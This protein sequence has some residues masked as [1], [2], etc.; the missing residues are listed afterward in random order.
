MADT[1]LNY[2]ASPTGVKFHTSDAFVKGIMGPFGSG[3]SVTVCWDIFMRMKKQAAGSD[4]IRRTRWIIA[5]NTFSELENTTMATWKDWFPER[6]FGFISRKPP[7]RQ[8]IKYDDV[9][10]EIIFLALDK[11]EDQKKLLSFEVTGIWFNEARQIPQELILAA[12]GRVGRYPAR[13]DK[14]GNVDENQWPSWSGILLDTNPPDDTHWY[15]KAAEED[16]WAVNNDGEKVPPESI[17]IKRQ[18]HFFRQ[19]SGLSPQAENIENLPG[20]IEYYQRMLGGN[21]KEWVD[22]HV[23]GNYGF[24]KE[25]MPV[26]EGYWNPDTMVKQINKIPG[27]NIWV[28]IDSSGRHPATVFLQ[29]SSLGQWQVVR[30]YLADANGVG[31]ERYADQLRTFMLSE[32]PNH[33]FYEWGDP[34]GEW[35]TQNDERVYF[36]ILKAKGINVKAS[37]GLRI[38]ERLETVK[39]V[40]GRSINGEPGL[41]I[42]PSCKVLI[43]GLNGGYRYR[44]ISTATSE[45]YDEKP[46]KNRFSDVQDAL[47]Y[48]LCGAGELRKVLGR[49]KNIRGT[50]TANTEFSI[51]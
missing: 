3:K 1:V 9:E 33:E 39:S 47:Q 45:R 30:E 27:G 32:F 14:P 5:R 21:T 31:A 15:Y 51:F 19:P 49:K 34:A 46:E 17:P 40:M 23:H 37:P 29:K 41:I 18:W 25:G 2:K 42:D 13:K 12:L 20:G 38:P 6:T 7:Y 22:V 8:T 26:Y 28:G 43:R 48:A 36:D 4:G 44:K 50:I 10:A 35:K 16:A 11:P 24:I